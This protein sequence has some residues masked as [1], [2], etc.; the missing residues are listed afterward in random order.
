[1]CGVGIA[2]SLGGD[3]NDGEVRAGLVVGVGLADSEVWAGLVR[4]WTVGIG[5]GAFEVPFDPHDLAGVGREFGM[6]RQGD[7][8]SRGDI[9]AHV[10]GCVVAGGAGGQAHEDPGR[11]LAELAD[12]WPGTTFMATAAAVHIGRATGD[13]ALIDKALK[14]SEAVSNQIFDEGGRSTKGYAFGTPESWFVDETLIC[15][16]T[17]YARARAVWQLVD[18]LDP[19]PSHP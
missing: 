19:L 2:V 16:Y 5:A 8:V 6:G 3:P 11:Y 4:P 15:R 17:G 18:A 10:I 1:M 14:M 9:D 7:D 12:V 13:D